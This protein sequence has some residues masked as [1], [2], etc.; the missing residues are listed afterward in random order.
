ME[1]HCLI[2]SRM[3]ILF[4]W[5]SSW[6]I[7]WSTEITKCLLCPFSKFVLEN[8]LPSCPPPTNY[9]W[10]RH[11]PTLEEL[12]H[13]WNLAQLWAGSA[14]AVGQGQNLGHQTVGCTPSW[15]TLPCAFCG[16]LSVRSQ[17][18][19]G[20]DTRLHTWP[21]SWR[22]ARCPRFLGPSL[23]SFDLKQ[24]CCSKLHVPNILT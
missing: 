19:Q 1:I 16:G 14:V 15:L 13:N 11:C 24:Y 17:M 3:I 9:R 5:L 4:F 21:T 7:L 10:G 22:Q 6:R 8:H 23:H 20:D 2:G 18:F 12:W